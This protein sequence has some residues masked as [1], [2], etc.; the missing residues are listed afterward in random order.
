MFFISYIISYSLKESF[1]EHLRTG[2]NFHSLLFT[3]VLSPLLSRELKNS[4]SV[5]H[6]FKDTF[7]C[8]WGLKIILKYFLLSLDFKAN[9]K[10]EC[11]ESNIKS[12]GWKMPKN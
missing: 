7:S 11:Q 4:P 8:F 9:V 12:R 2:S 10:K 3:R 6:S 5:S 1:V